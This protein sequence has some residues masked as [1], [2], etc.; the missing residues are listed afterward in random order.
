VIGKCVYGVDV[1]PM[2]V[3]LC[4]VALWMEAVEPGKPLSFLKHRIQCGN[5]LLGTTPALLSRGIPDEAFEPI[6]GD[7]KA[8]CR[9]WKKTNKREREDTRSGQRTLEDFLPHLGNFAAEMAAMDT[10]PDDTPDQ[11]R[12]K[13]ERYE[14]L[15][16][17][18]SYRTSGRFLADVWCAAFV[19]RKARG[20]FD[21]PVT[22]RIFR[23]VETNPNAVEPWIY[24]EVVRLRE[25]YQFFHWH[26]A[27]PGVFRPAA[28]GGKPDNELT[29]WCGGFDVVLGN[30]PWERIKLQEQE[31]FAAH[32][33]A[34]IAGART[35]AIRSRLIHELATSE[36]ESDRRMHAAFLDDR[37]AAE[38]ESHLVRQ[39]GRYPL[40]GRG[41]LN[42]YGLF[43]ELN[44]DLISGHGRV[45][46]ILPS[47]IA[48]E[49]TNKAF[50]QEAV[51]SKSL[52]SFFDFENR[53]GIFPGVHRSYRFA[54]VTLA[55]CMQPIRGATDFVFF[56]Y[57]TDDLT[58][59]S[60]RF[61]LSAADLE[62]LKPNTRTCPVFSRA[63]DAVL[64]K[65]IYY[66]VPVLNREA[67][68]GANPWGVQIRQGLFHL[69]NDLT[70]GLLL[71]RRELPSRS[72]AEEWEVPVYEGKLI[73]QFCHQFAT[74]SASGNAA[75]IQEV[76]QRT[77]SPTHSVACRYFTKLPTL[78][79]RVP[80]TYRRRWFVTFRDIARVTDSRTCIAAVVPRVGI[81]YT[82]R[83]IVQWATSPEGSACLYAS[84][85]TFIF[86]YTVRQAISGTHVSDYILKQV[87]ALP[88]STYT[89]L[90]P[91]SPADTL[92]A[93]LLP[94]VVEL[95]YTAW[96]LQP[97]AADCGFDGPPFR[98][99]DERR[100][101]LRCELDA[102]FFHLYFGI[103][104]WK[105][106]VGEQDADLG[107]LKEAFPTPRHAAEYVMNTFPIVREQD[108]QAH[109]HYR[110][111]DRIL[112]V[113]D[114]LG[115]AVRTGQPYCSPLDPPPADPRCRHA[116][117]GGTL[118]PGAVR[119]IADLL[120][121]LPPGTFPLRLTEADIGPGQA[122]DWA[123]QPLTDGEPLPPEG[124]WVL[125]RSEALRRG[126]TPLSIAAGRLALNPI[127]DGM[128]VLLKGAI[129]PATLRLT[130]EQ[131]KT[132]RPLAV[133]TPLALPE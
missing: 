83:V 26:L 12:A 14:R 89:A 111:K 3:E 41:D 38:G 88:P 43:A 128:E 7:E 126:P 77:T 82:L 91:W 56:A 129:P 107:R 19:W 122:R 28:R 98:W 113:Y 6:E 87:P 78:G 127:A 133:L 58:D 16:S 106:G 25:Q 59:P 37:R 93:W 103:G 97:F 86:D 36:K 63:R 52:V 55:G 117:H 99:D 46:C 17:E 70:A 21:F 4:Q 130:A 29:G 31:W 105:R 71:D 69:T 125:L 5:S 131:W 100:F 114:A 51:A 8:Y 72:D 67:A 34:D 54:L 109:S 116:D 50:F 101:Q 33:R 110:T 66:R 121:V 39:S 15:A 115:D 49:D 13:A 95:T 32:G 76:D 68:Q 9:D 96:D 92:T 94:R 22:E 123:C 57:S 85:N 112:T 20:A 48:T 74:Y 53:D 104:D 35:A 40:C 2:A 24:D 75:D 80:E 44:R 45:G 118:A 84:L 79:Q 60:K 90:C 64:A 10:L 81:A 11:V 65:A 47:G 18:S 73:H 1:N 61:T 132:F 23:R 42:T 62:L 30:P 120:T 124:T 108:E 27:F 119:T 102:A